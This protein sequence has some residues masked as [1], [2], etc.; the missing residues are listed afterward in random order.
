MKKS[1]ENDVDNLRRPRTECLISTGPSN[2][3]DSPPF[4]W[5]VSLFIGWLFIAMILPGCGGGPRPV[6]LTGIV[7]FQG[8]PVPHGFIT[9]TPVKPEA[10]NV[11]RV[12]SRVQDGKYVAARGQGITGGQEYQVEVGGFPRAQKS[13]EDQVSPLFPVWSTSLMTPERG[14]DL[15]VDVKP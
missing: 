9:F 3:G 12:V 2:Q 13:E 4:Q 7:T 6:E 15:N 10:G 11:V 8:K 1:R 5:N 14:G